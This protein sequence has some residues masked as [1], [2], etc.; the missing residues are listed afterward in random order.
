[1]LAPSKGTA[2]LEIASG[3]KLAK[4]LAA[5]HEER[6]RKL[7]KDKINEKYEKGQRKA[8]VVSRLSRVN[9]SMGIR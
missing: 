7:W 4:M 1:M 3:R 8:G 6:L 9:I 5:V 2:S